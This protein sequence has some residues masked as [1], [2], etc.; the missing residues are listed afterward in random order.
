[1]ENG[2]DPIMINTVKTN[3]KIA[4]DVKK[5]QYVAILNEFEKRMLRLKIV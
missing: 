4:Y 1:V 5:N 3:V 2:S